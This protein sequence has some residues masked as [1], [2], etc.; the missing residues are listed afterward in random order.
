M[1]DK[2]AQV[3]PTIS[4]FSVTKGGKIAETY[5]CFAHWDLDVGLDEN[6][7]RFQ[8][9]NPIL[10][11]T[12]AWLKEM[13]RIL[14]VRFGDIER[15]VPLIRLAQSRMPQEEWA[16]ILL[17]HL[18]FRELLLSEFLVNW[19][20]QRKEE[21][22]L[23]LDSLDVRAYLT[24]L[25]GRGLVEK[26]WTENTINKMAGSL[27]SY[28][29]DFGLIRGRSNREILPYHLPDKALLYVLYWLKGETANSERILSDERWRIYLLSRGELEQELYRLHQHQRLRFET[30]GTLAVLELPHE[31]VDEYVETVLG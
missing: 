27:P 18:C 4:T 11:P 5:A 30:A 14:R 12:D 22:F 24:E 28:A 9:E 16:P 7:D 23:R 17:W 29:A 3:T 19:L 26:D 31:S 21:G 15:H 6:L 20:F 10:A 25:R 13:R 1:A 2:K 8:R